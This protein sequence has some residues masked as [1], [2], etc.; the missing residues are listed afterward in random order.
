MKVDVEGLSCGYGDSRILRDVDVVL[1]EP[2]LICII[3]PNGVGKSTFVKCILKLL[4]RDSGTVEID[5]NDIDSVSRKELA[6][7]MGF[8][9]AGSEETFSMTVLEYVMM[10]RHPHK[11][12]EGNSPELDWN[13]SVRA[14][15]MMGIRD[16]AMRNTNE[17]SA[18]QRQR[19]AIAKGLAQTPRILFLDEPTANLDPRYQLQVTERIR[20]IS[21]ETGMTTVMI[22]HD[23]N[24][25]AK[26]ADEVVIMAKPGRIYAV[27]PPSEVITADA[28]RDVYGVE[29][30]VVDDDGRPHVILKRA[31]GED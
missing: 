1:G 30:T 6:K 2:G 25:S 23:L 5:G 7:V 15:K 29:C 3:G 11:N 20:D 13:I 14:L 12:A 17:L 27:G 31:V 4:G 19:A 26:F 28:I 21:K 16:L 24:V 10:G 18:G 9:P 22:S 8:V